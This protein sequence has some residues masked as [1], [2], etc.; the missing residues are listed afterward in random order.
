LGARPDLESLVEERPGLQA[1]FFLDR[2]KL[3]L[4]ALQ[5]HL[6]SILDVFKALL[7]LLKSPCCRFI[8]LVSI[9][10][11]LASSYA[12]AGDEVKNTHLSFTGMSVQGIFFSAQNRQGRSPEHLV[13]RALQTSHCNTSQPS[14]HPLNGKIKQSKRARTA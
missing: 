11:Q 4:H 12:A 14:N 2:H 6:K 13:F 5:S 3:V 8:V 10:D 1:A 9:R 7:D